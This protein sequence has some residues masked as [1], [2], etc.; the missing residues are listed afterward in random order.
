MHALNNACIHLIER[1]ARDSANGCRDQIRNGSLARPIRRPS[2][3]PILVGF[4]IG[5][6]IGFGIVRL[7]RLLS[8]PTPTHLFTK[9]R[10]KRQLSQ[11]ASF[12]ESADEQVGRATV[13]TVSESLRVLRRRW[14]ETHL[15]C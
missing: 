14:R 11:A 12:L 10:I 4:R 13:C 1:A 2:A 3:H 15:P 6:R 8:V 7:R 5:F 9:L